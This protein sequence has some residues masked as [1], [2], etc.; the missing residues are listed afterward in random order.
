MQMTETR[1]R[2][3]MINHTLTAKSVELMI[4]QDCESHYF[5]FLNVSVFQDGFYMV[6]NLK[7]LVKYTFKSFGLF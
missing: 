3:F 1:L 2:Y 6:T 5:S 7:L 4:E